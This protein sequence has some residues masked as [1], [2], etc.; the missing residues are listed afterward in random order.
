MCQGLGWILGIADIVYHYFNQYL[1]VLTL[2]STPH[3]LS[4]FLGLYGRKGNQSY[5]LLK[6]FVFGQISIWVYE[7]FLHT[8]CVA[9]QQNICDTYCINI[10]QALSKSC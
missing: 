2:T 9:R 5:K 4:T 3:F 7:L 6:V 10:P 8:P 1:L